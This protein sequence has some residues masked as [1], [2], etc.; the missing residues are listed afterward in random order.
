MVVLQ[1]KVKSCL[2]GGV[3]ELQAA[4]VVLQDKVPTT[5]QCMSFCF[6]SLRHRVSQTKET[7]VVFRQC[8][9][10]GKNKPIENKTMVLFQA[11]QLV[12]V[13]ESSLVE[14][15]VHIS[16]YFLPGHFSQTFFKL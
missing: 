5:Y 10:F 6:I 1:D 3:E 8:C 12:S 7:L 14:E 2:Q 4:M 9:S 15:G 16:F 11:R 13:C